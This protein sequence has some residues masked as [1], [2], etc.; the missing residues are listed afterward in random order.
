LAV[1]NQLR[2]FLYVLAAEYAPLFGNIFTFLEPRGY[3]NRSEMSFSGPAYRN[4]KPEGKW[5]L[6]IIAQTKYIHSGTNHKKYHV[7]LEYQKEFPEDFGCCGSG[8]R[9]LVV[10]GGMKFFHTDAKPLAELYR[11][12]TSGDWPHMSV[13][14]GLYLAMKYPEIEVNSLQQIK[15]LILGDQQEVSAESAAM[16]D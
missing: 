6:R 4:G 1:F 16:M 5:S 2:I 12:F 11:V 13:G 9:R 3:P 10:F 8:P 14:L 7:F 15:N